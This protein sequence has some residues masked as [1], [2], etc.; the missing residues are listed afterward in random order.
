M[1]SHLWPWWL[2]S[3]SLIGKRSAMVARAFASAAPRDAEIAAGG[4]SIR[5]LTGVLPRPLRVIPY[6]VM[7]ATLEKVPQE[8]LLH[9]RS[10]EYLSSGVGHSPQFDISRSS[11]HCTAKGLEIFFASDQPGTLGGLD[12]WVSTR[13]TV[14]DTWSTPVSGFWEVEL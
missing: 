11:T 12:L 1:C 5:I 3:C 8:L 2:F 7:E 9:R 14:F 4:G 10:Q 6:S 13:A